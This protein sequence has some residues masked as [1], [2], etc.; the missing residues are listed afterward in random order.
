MINTGVSLRRVDGNVNSG[1][2][3]EILD[4]ICDG[5]AGKAYVLDEANAGGTIHLV[6]KW[7]TPRHLDVTYDGRAVV[8]LQVVKLAEVEISL[9][10]TSKQTGSNSQ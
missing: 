6:M 7:E 8:N 9:R 10:D 5:P 2:P 1:K 4:F 3:F